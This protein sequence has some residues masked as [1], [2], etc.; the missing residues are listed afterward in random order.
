[1]AR[2][3]RPTKLTAQERLLQQQEEELRRRE[4]ELQRKLKQIPAQLEEK[5]RRERELVRQ[6][7]AASTPAIS[8]GGARATRSSRAQASRGRRLPASELQ[9]ARIKFIVLCV[10]LATLVILLWR[11]IPT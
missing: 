1:M 2:P 8:L 9:T 11:S 7:V 5:R 3:T 4:Q 6:R 10:I